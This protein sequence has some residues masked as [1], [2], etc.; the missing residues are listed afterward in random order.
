MK[1]MCENFGNNEEVN[2]VEVKSFRKI[3]SFGK[4]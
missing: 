2:R 4:R 1:E 3:K